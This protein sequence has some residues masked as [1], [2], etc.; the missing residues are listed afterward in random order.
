MVIRYNHWCNR[1]SGIEIIFMKHIRN[2]KKIAEDGINLKSKYNKALVCAQLKSFF[3]Y[4]SDEELYA[5][6]AKVFRA[7][8]AMDDQPRFINI[9][10]V[11][12]TDQDVL[13]MISSYPSMFYKQREYK[14]YHMTYNNYAQF[15]LPV[16]KKVTELLGGGSNVSRVILSGGISALIT[17]LHQLLDK[18]SE[19]EMKDRIKNN[20]ELLETFE[21][22]IN[23][24]QL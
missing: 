8:S 18:T 4:S 19:Y 14:I 22:K 10:D 16:D 23:H 1:V 12:D 5:D 13:M 15:G 11:F 24:V 3:V 17:L 2:I 20:I 21:R 6:Q 7:W 9:K